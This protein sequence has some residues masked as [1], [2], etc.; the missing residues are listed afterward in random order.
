[1]CNV[2]A[3][4]VYDIGNK[5][6]WGETVTKEEYTKENYTLSEK[7][8][9]DIYGNPKYDVARAY[10]GGTWRM[11][12]KEEMEELLEKCNCIRLSISGHEVFKVTG[13]NGNSIIFPAIQSFNWMLKKDGFWSASCWSSSSSNKKCSTWEKD[14][15]TQAY[16]LSFISYKPDSNSVLSNP[17]YMGSSVRAVSE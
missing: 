10:W 16:I 6:A 7:E 5:Y 17:C 3:T 8:I 15:T 11:P 9:G 13:P 2:G 12:T 14:N 1:T 4:T